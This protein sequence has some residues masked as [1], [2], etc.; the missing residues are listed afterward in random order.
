[1][2]ILCYEYP[3]D[4]IPTLVLTLILYSF[5]HITYHNIES[6]STKC[7]II[8]KLFVINYVVARHNRLNYEL[9]PCE[10]I[11]Q[12]NVNEMP[13]EEYVTMS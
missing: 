12:L 11:H 6:M 4:A 13:L 10:R 1:M 8:V 3:N 7:R 5:N 9:N 2:K